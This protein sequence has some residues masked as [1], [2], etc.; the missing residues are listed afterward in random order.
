MDYNEFAETVKS[1]HPE[2]KDRDN[3]QLAQAMVNK[4]PQYKD[5]VTFDT[6]ASGPTEALITNKP[7]SGFMQGIARAVPAI[8][9][10]LTA[11]PEGAAAGAAAGLPFGPYGALAGGLIGG[12]GAAY[13][14]GVGGEAA[15]QAV[16]QGVAVSNPRKNY[17]IL[18]SNKLFQALHA[19]GKEQALNEVGGRVVGE[20]MPIVNKAAGAAGRGLEGISGLE[21]KSPG[22][23]KEAAND[24]SLLFGK[25][26]KAAGLAYETIKDDLQVRPSMLSATSHKEIIDDAKY[27]LENGDLSPQEALIARQAIDKS[28]DTVPSSTVNYLRPKFDAIA[29]TI[30]KDADEW[31]KRALKSEALQKIFATNKSG[32]TS[33]AKLWGALVAGGGVGAIPMSPVVQ[34]AAATATGLAGRA[35]EN[36]PNV[37]RGA[38]VSAAV[39]ALLNRR[40]KDQANG[41]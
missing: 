13:V 2:Y 23:L 8:A 5:R 39:Q 32:G 30:T 18:D 41:E 36:S 15:R 27:A 28:R 22:V 17:P 14:G 38:P 37:L 3:L 1:K 16:A 20:A 10:A 35:I 33:V 34:G 21:Y 6:K 25:G 26:K 4:F 31:F 7:T 24:S 29:K 40:K 12:V 11:V 9:G 19:S